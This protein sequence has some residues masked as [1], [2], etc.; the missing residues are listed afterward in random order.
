MAVLDQPRPRLVGQRVGVPG[1][2]VL[3]AGLVAAAALLPVV[4]TSSTTATGAEIRRLEVER[5][6]LQARINAKQAEVAELGSIE[7]IDREARERLGMVP[8]TRLMYIT[9]AQPPPETGMPARYLNPEEP[10][11]AQTKPAPW[12]RAALNGLRFP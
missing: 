5:S 7:R 3:A 10:Q 8:A 1:L 9:V 6:D 2:V 4:Q 12:W 11:A